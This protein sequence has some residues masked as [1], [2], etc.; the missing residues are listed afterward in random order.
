MAQR[1]IHTAVVTGPTG[2]VGAALCECLLRRGIEVHAVVRPGSAR[3]AAL[4]AGA[5]A[6]PCDLGD[7]AALPEAL[8]GTRADAFFHLAWAGTTG[9][10]RNDV[11]EQLRNI[12]CAVDAARAAAAMGCRVFVGA[13]SQAEYGRFEGK[14][15][16]DTPAFPETA[17][18]MAKLCAGQM[19]RLECARLGVDHVWARILSVYGPRDRADS[20]ISQTIRALL[21]GEAPALTGC[22]QRW[23]FL[24]ADDAAEALCLC[25]ERGGHGA[26][27]PLGSGRAMP[28]KTYVETLRDAIDPRLALRYGAIPY[29]RSQVMHLEADLSALRADTGFSPATPFERGIEKTIDWVKASL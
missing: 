18:G 9:E 23:D 10:A 6:L 25:A 17:Y 12:R 27:Y 28:L 8:H 24:Y 29:A 19:T 15:A 11:E 22:E 20:M 26:V 2:A 13:G 21:R 3:L 4:P 14:L 1:T 5:R 16:Q 7:M